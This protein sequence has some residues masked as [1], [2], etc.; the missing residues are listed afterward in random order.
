MNRAERQLAEARAARDEARAR[1]D[2]QLNRLRGD[3]QAQSIGE[4]LIDRLADDA[5]R[6]M[7][8]ALDVAGESK[9][10]AAATA[11]LLVVWIL[12]KPILAWIGDL[13]DSHVPADDDS[14]AAEEVSN[15]AQE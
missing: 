13:W 11:A 14:D 7:D 8:R 15:N 9:S 2:A 5:R 6:S 4:R 3:A 12:R 10:I 1:F